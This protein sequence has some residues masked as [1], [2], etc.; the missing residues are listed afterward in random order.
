MADTVKALFLDIGGVMLTNGWG[1]DSRQKAEAEFGLDHSEFEDR[2]S[3]M[4]GAFEEGWYSLDDYLKYV[5][6]YKQRS[7]SP[8]E[9]KSFMYDRSQPF[10]EMLE[11]VRVL[12][13]RYHLKIFA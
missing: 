6:F 2:H 1:R 5:I 3:L 9:F 8:D 10:P 4:F 12:K 13:E 11:L 7:F